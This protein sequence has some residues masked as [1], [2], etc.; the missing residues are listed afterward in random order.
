MT[1]YKE[2]LKAVSRLAMR[3]VQCSSVSMSQV[4]LSPVYSFINIYQD[5]FNV[6]VSPRCYHVHIMQVYA[7]PGIIFYIY[8]INTAT[9]NAVK[10]I[11]GWHLASCI[12]HM[13]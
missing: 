2:E 10:S 9:T 12:V 8:D 6:H 4:S 13:A 7:Q 3:Q 11:G 5:L 1:K